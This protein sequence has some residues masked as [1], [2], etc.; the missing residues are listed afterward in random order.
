[1]TTR[2]RRRSGPAVPLPRPRMML[3]DTHN[4]EDLQPRRG[5]NRNRMMADQVRIPSAAAS[6]RIWRPSAASRRSPRQKPKVLFCRA[7]AHQE[8]A[9]HRHHLVE[10]ARRLQISD[11]IVDYYFN[12]KKLAYTCSSAH[13]P[14]C[15]MLDELQDWDATWYWATTAVRTRP[16]NGASATAIRAR[17]CCRAK[18]SPANENV[19]LGNIRELAGGRS[20]I[21]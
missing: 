10:H 14:V 7:H 15:L 17:C 20:S 8:V 9:A 3:G 16:S 6:R 11:A 4:T 13:E 5:Y 2:F 1:M 18:P 19:V 12:K 21:C